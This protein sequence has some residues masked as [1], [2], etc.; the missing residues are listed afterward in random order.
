M[1]L[2][3]YYC[4]VCKLYQSRLL[5]VEESRGDVPC[6]TDGCA[7]KLTRKA[8]PPSSSFK[9]THD[10]GAM[11]RKVETYPDIHEIM[12]KRSNDDER[13]RRLDIFKED[14]NE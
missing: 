7:G 14:P 13:N 11:V 5:S 4:P 6:K 1:P 9:E 3:S 10:N 12:K 2:F 8:K